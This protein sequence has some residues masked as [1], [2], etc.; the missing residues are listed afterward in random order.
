MRFVGDEWRIWTSPFRSNPQRTHTIKKY[1]V[2]FALISG[3]LI[4]TDRYTGSVLPNTSD[5]AMWSG[6][7]S[8]LGAWYS[9]A[10]ISGGTYLMGRLVDNDHAKE[11]GLLALEALGHAQI[12]VFAFKQ[13]TNRQRPLDDD[14]KGSF[15]EGGTS[16]PSGHSASSFAVATVFAYEY[17]EHLAIPIVAY[18]LASA[19]SASRLAAR[20]HWVSDIVVGGS[21]GFLIGRFTY[22]RN[23]DPRLPGASVRSARRFIPQIG[24]SGS[25]VLLSWRL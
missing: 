20:R 25:S 16:F 15:W 1:I 11:A 8:Q 6:R 9:L 4:A 10:G 14:G 13:A 7:V 19:I 2:P 3:A 24:I 22:K 23:H 12:V 17:R 21:L 5:Q 18:S